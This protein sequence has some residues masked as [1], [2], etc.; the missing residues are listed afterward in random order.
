MMDLFV[1]IVNGFQA[2]TIFTKSSIIDVLTVLKTPL[3]LFSE[4]GL[5]E[6]IGQSIDA[7]S[8][9]LKRFSS[10]KGY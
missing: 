7:G 1:K 5:T 6:E 8:L 10:S 3:V 9:V 2:F 4:L